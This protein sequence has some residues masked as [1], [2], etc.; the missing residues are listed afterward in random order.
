[1][2]TYR[3]LREHDLETFGGSLCTLHL[4]VAA[5]M[6]YSDAVARRAY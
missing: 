1:M 4:V 5:N 6:V 3:G 2:F